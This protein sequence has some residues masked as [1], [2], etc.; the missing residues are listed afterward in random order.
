MPTHEPDIDDG[1]YDEQLNPV[2]IEKRIREINGDLARLIRAVDECNRSY[3]E[4]KRLHDHAFAHAYRDYQ[5]PQGEKRQA[6][7]IAVEDER[8]YMD[9]AKAALDYARDQADALTK[10]LSAY[11]SLNKS[12]MQ[13]YG[14]SN[15]WGS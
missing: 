14:S 11:Q 9:N 13:M 4:A 10:E 8:E 7:V 6:A 3:K 1:E 15:G 5:G 2:M 12:V